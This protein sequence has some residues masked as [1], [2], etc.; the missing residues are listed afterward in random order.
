MPSSS[1]TS[2]NQF[3]KNQCCNTSSV[4]QMCHRNTASHCNLNFLESNAQNPQINYTSSTSSTIEC[5][6]LLGTHSSKQFRI[7]LARFAS[8]TYFVEEGSEFKQIQKS[9]LVQLIPVC[10][11]YTCS[12][13][14][15]CTKATK[16][17][18]RKE[19]LSQMRDLLRN[20]LPE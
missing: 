10:F 4:T 7:I 18:S 17:I 11:F 13:A 2:R 9:S 3:Y 19:K 16:Y 6:F 12:G 1:T 5:R 14:A 8:V 20:I 15:A